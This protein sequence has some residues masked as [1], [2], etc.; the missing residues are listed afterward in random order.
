MSSEIAESFGRIIQEACP[1][2]LVRAIEKGGDHR[3][4]WRALEETGFIDALVPED[5]GGVGLSLNDAFP[6]A[7][8]CGRHA[9]PVPLGE[10][11]LLRSILA[12]AGVD[13][14]QG[15][16]TFAGPAT[17]GADGVVC[18]QV[19]C[20]RTADW[21]LVA[22]D[23]GC[24]LLSAAEAEQGPA[25]FALDASMRWTAAQI[26]AATPFQPGEDMLLVQALLHAI[27]LVGAMS[28]VFERTLGYANDRQQ[29]GRPIGKFQ[30]IQ[31]QLSV[32]AEHVFAARMAAEIAASR[33]GVRFDPLKIAIAKART[34]E[35]AVELAALSHSIH[36]AIGFTE[37]FDLQ[38]LTR[39]LHAWRQAAGTEGYWHQMIG[40]SLLDRGDS[41]SLDMLREAS[42]LDPA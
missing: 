20:G 19:P 31:H 13:I 16:M 38:L 1:P 8:Y 22:L 25:T 37:E 34:S 24:R 42:A 15:G 26:G 14:P 28:A 9:V 27:Q 33:D 5:K 41:M 10:T 39:R 12:R 7:E 6:I 17:R 18:S 30:A 21:V 3:P 35:A 32:M 40:R 4:L 11:M 2:D 29:F 36:G 23:D